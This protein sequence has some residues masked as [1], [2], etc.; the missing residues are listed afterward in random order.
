[1]VL[2]TKEPFDDFW[3]LALQQLAEKREFPALLLGT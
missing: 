2:S 1:M 3:G